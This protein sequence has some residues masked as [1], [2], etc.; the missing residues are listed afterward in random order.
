MGSVVQVL[1]G[2]Q[3]L[4]EGAVVELLTGEELQTLDQRRRAELELQMPSFISGDEDEAVAEFF[5]SLPTTSKF[6]R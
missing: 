6:D 5:S 1:G 4:P 2:V 3:T